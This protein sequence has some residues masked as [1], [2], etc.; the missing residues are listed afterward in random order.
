MFSYP[1]EMSLALGSSAPLFAT[2]GWSCLLYIA[3][4]ILNGEKRSVFKII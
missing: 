2:L 4:R 3:G 1:V